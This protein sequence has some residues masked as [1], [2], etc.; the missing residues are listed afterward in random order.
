MENNDKWVISSTGHHMFVSFSMDPLVLV[1]GPGFMA[2]IHYSNEKSII[3]VKI[4]HKKLYTN[5]QSIVQQLSLE[6]LDS[7]LVILVQSLKETVI[8]MTNVWKVSDVDQRIAWLHLDLI[9]T[10]IAVMLQ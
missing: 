1:S 7:V 8:L 2:K 9:H 10:Q 3:L 6:K 4:M 5:F